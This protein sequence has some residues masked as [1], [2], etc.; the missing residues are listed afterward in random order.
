MERSSV[1]L[2]TTATIS[3]SSRRAA[4]PLPAGLEQLISLNAEYHVLLCPNNACRQVLEPKVFSGHLLRIH[5]TKLELRRQVE[6][7]VV[8]FPHPYTYKTIPLLLDESRPSQS[9]P[10]WRGC[11]VST[12]RADPGAGSCYESIATRSTSSNE[13]RTKSSSA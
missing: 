13:R 1:T 4:K 9:S 7:Y 3:S 8:D 12:T 11:T 2:S 5:E 6:A 10:S